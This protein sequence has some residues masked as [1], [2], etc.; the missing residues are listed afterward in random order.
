M[1]PRIKTWHAV[2]AMVLV[3]IAIALFL[4]YRSQDSK[5][6]DRFADPERQGI[7]ESG[8]AACFTRA[9]MELAGSGADV[10]ESAIRSYCECAM[11]DVVEQLT[12]AEIERFN[13][14]EALSDEA[15]ATMNTIAAACSQQY[16]PN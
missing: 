9:R 2:A 12:D 8:L 1:P 16:L 11:G 6:P 3:G 13:E 4:F 5:S 14:T 10:A 15:M 7:Y